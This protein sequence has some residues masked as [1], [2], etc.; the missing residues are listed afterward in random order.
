MGHPF[1]TGLIIGWLVG[2]VSA[3]FVLSLV[4]VAGDADEQA[5]IK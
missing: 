4:R 5:G 2:G 1:I 3:V